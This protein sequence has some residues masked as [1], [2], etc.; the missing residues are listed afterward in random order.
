MTVGE[1]IK[2]LRKQKGLT[3]KQLGSLCEP[4]IGEST[5]RKYELGLLNPKIETIR[6]IADALGVYIGRI[7]E[8]WGVD[9]SNNPDEYR[10]AM[11]KLS[12]FESAIEKKAE[13]EEQK[14]LDSYWKLNKNGRIE[15]QKRVS[16]LTEIPKYQEEI[17]KLFAGPHPLKDLPL[18]STIELD[19]DE[20]KKEED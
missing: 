1:N 4:K 18:S 7:D 5:I 20:D 10:K 17:I 19:I 6:R 3:Q 12:E 11:N 8:E 15:A 2:K 14:L 13:R 9:I 16:E